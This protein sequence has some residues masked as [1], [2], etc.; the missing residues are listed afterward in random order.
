M[1]RSLT[2]GRVVLVLAIAGV[3]SFALGTG[4]GAQG[5][6]PIPCIPFCTP[7]TLEGRFWEELAPDARSL[8]LDLVTVEVYPEGC[9]RIEGPLYLDL[10]QKRI[11]LGP[12]VVVRPPGFF[13]IQIFAPARGEWD[14]G[15]LPEGRYAFEVIGFG[16]YT[17]EVT[18]ESFKLEPEAILD[19]ILL[20]PLE[21]RRVPPGALWAGIRPEEERWVHAFRKDLKARGAEPCALPAGSYR[22]FNFGD[23]FEV[24]EEGVAAGGRLKT[25]CFADHQD[26]QKTQTFLQQARHLVCIY[27]RLFTVEVDLRTWRGERFKGCPE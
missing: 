6:P 13:C 3:L 12:L 21:L 19:F 24:D 5:Q 4:P 25:F 9:Y 1:L 10:E 16:R 15:E 22:V 23:R 27:E 18:Q 8:F 7:Q 11:I 14:F 2:V 26:E 17:L 20:E